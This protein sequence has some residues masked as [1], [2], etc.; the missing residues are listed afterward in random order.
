MCLTISSRC[1]K[2]QQQ[3][4]CFRWC[5]VVSVEY[6]FTQNSV[7][8]RKPWN[9]NASLRSEGIHPL[10]WR[11]SHS[12]RRK[13]QPFPWLETDLHY[14][15]EFSSVQKNCNMIAQVHENTHFKR[16][17]RAKKYP[18]CHQTDCIIALLA[19]CL[20][21]HMQVLTKGFESLK[22]PRYCFQANIV[23]CV[24]LMVRN[25]ELFGV[26]D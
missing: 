10:K 15:W 17:F 26:Q 24:W 2:F 19:I 13:L 6:F 8:Y 3:E 18:V 21:S 25:T 16:P 11:G 9:N 22:R 5:L 4:K 20:I 23:S 12:S 1:F 7:S 14:D